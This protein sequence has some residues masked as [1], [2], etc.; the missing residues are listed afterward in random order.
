MFEDL[1]LKYVGPVDGHDVAGRRAGAA[2]RPAL[3][4]PGDRARRHPEGPRLRAGR[5]RRGRPVPR[6]RRLRPRDRAA[7]DGARPDLDR[8]CSPTRWC[9]IGAERP[10]VVAI[11]AAM[12]HPV[13]LARA[14]PSAFPDRIF[15]VGIAEQHAVTSAAGLAIGGLHPVV[16]VYATFLNRAFDQ[17]LMD[18]ALHRAGVT[19]V[20]DRAGV[21]GN[22]GASHNGMWDMSILLGRARACGWP[23]RA[24]ASRLREA[25]ARGGRRRR[26]ARRCVRFPKGA[27]PSRPPRAGAARAAV[28]VL[29]P[30]RPRSTCCSSASARWPPRR[31]PSPEKLQAQG[32]TVRVVDPRWVLPVSG[33]RRG[34]PRSQGG[35]EAS[36]VRPIRSRIS[37]RL[38]WSRNSCGMPCSAERRRR[39]RASSQGLQQHRAAAAD[40]AVVLDADHQPVLAGERRR[41]RGRPA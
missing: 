16:A 28:D 17:L 34:G 29:R 33:P 1:G 4:R 19:F 26:R 14:S 31:W 8:R 21:T 41:A 25:A 2:P 12:L 35:G 22:D 10:D 32:R 27:P 5:E 30:G 13:G 38:A 3:R 37:A 40:D 15:D 11:T 6:R 36:A 39:R 23:P 7:V 9:A 18:V 20:L 24:T